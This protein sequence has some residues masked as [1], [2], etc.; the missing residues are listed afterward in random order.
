MYSYFHIHPFSLTPNKTISSYFSYSSNCLMHLPLHHTAVYQPV[1]FTSKSSNAVNCHLYQ[2]FRTKWQPVSQVSHCPEIPFSQL[3]STNYSH[4]HSISRKC[5][6]KCCDISPFVSSILCDREQEKLLI[7]PFYSSLNFVW[8]NPGE[9]VP[10][11]TSIWIVN[12]SIKSWIPNTS[13]NLYYHPL[14]LPSHSVHE[15]E[16]IIGLYHRENLTLQTAIFLLECCIWMHIDNR[17]N[18]P[19]NSV[20]CS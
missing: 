3:T 6:L 14:T 20:Y 18:Y 15:P 2:T 13:C 17:F 9:P 8:D 5:L 11:E 19:F 16:H 7:Q 10:E 12:C 4:I 1:C